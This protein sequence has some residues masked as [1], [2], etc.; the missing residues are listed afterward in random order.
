MGNI[1]WTKSWS[2]SD[3][4]TILY[5]ADLENI[6]NDITNVVNGGLTNVNINGSAA[7]EES[8]IAFNI[9]T[10]HSH[11]G[12]DS[13]KINTD[14]IDNIVIANP[15]TGEILVYDEGSGT[16]I[17]A[18]PLP[19]GSVVGYG[20]TTAPTGWLLCN[21]DAVSRTTY[22]RLFGI[23][24]TTFG[25]GDGTTTFNVPVT[26]N[27]VIYGADAGVAAGNADVGSA[28][29]RTMAGND[30]SVTLSSGTNA[31]QDGGGTA[32][33]QNVDM[34]VPYLALYH[35]IRT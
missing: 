19:P 6:Q 11:D 5:G 2:S 9:T 1:V 7:I 26:K 32:T 29:D 23:I 24:G 21:G 14:D 3:D 30:S 33:P 34:M 17:N 35:I 15:E 10:G 8:K 20:G 22:S 18:T 13:R 12:T 4:G 31:K 16:W 25:I 27:R 28:K